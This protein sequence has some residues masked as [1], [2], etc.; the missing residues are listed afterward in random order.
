MVCDKVS[1]TPMQLIKNVLIL[2][3]LEYGLRLRQY[4]ALGVICI[5]LNPYSIG[6]WS[7]TMSQT[8]IPYSTQRL[9][10]YSIGIWS[11]TA[12]QQ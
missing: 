10:P 11:A 1:R 8:L 7:A 9:N 2:I 6:I 5:S 12:S 3:L 4:D